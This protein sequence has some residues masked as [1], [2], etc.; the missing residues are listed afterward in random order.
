M[1]T[2]WYCN[3]NIPL[4]YFLYLGQCMGANLAKHNKE[5]PSTRK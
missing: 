3:A 4:V 2:V 5:K 1:L